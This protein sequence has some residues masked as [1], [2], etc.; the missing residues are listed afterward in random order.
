M[1]RKTDEQGQLQELTLL[2]LE[3]APGHPE[4]AELTRQLLRH[5]M[6]SVEA[7]RYQFLYCPAKKKMLT[8]LLEEEEGFHMFLNNVHMVKK[9]ATD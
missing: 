4:A 9:I 7:S 5:V 8:G 1:R 2:Q 3:T 6:T